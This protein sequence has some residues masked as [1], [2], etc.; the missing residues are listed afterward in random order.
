MTR[1]RRFYFLFT[2]LIFGGTFLSALDNNYFAF[3]I[4]PQ[5]EIANGIIKEYVFEDICL[6]TDNKE[7]QLDWNVKT[8]ALF[9]L[10]ADFDII[11][12]ISLGFSGSFAVPQ[13][14][15]FMQDYDW[16]NSVTTGWTDED[17][18]ECTNFSEHI[19]KLDKYIIF[20]AFL[21]GNIYLPAEIKVTPRLGYRY[22]FIRF[23]GY[24]GYSDYKWNNHQIQSFTGKVI[25]YEQEINSLLLG[26]NIKLACIPRTIINL[27]FDISPRAGTLN[28]I[29]YHYAR[30]T[31]FLDKFTK[32]LL[33]ESG[34]RV[35]YAFSKNHSA[36][37]SGS[38][39]YIPLSKGSTYNRGIN[40]KGE[41]TGDSWQ[42]L[43][44]CNGGTERFIWSLG[45]NYSFSL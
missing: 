21:G 3:C 39:Q 41:L 28:A 33:L 26:L 15:G 6:N 10:Q 12:Y 1:L 25:S 19:N 5:F 22:E 36:G 4:T 34:L 14:S 38:L 20:K 18:T 2:I 42:A 7:S 31:A 27:N 30:T 13:R 29:D 17:P 8:I 40:R 35:Q 43:S 16:L 23:T 45:L 11:R 24:Y 44:G 32:L 37:I 9:G